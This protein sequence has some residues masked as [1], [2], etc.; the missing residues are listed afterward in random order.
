MR[1]P[2]IMSQ[3]TD[4]FPVAPGGTPSRAPSR[5]PSMIGLP[6]SPRISL[7][8]WAERTASANGL[9]LRDDTGGLNSPLTQASITAWPDGGPVGS[10]RNG[11]EPSSTAEGQRRPHSQASFDTA[12]RM[13]RRRQSTGFDR[14]DDGHSAY[15]PDGSH[16]MMTSRGRS[17]RLAPSRPQSVAE[18]DDTFGPVDS[19]SHDISPS[20]QNGVSPKTV[21]TEVLPSL[22]SLEIVDT[23]VTE[24][25]ANDGPGI[26]NGTLDHPADPSAGVTSRNMAATVEKGADV[27]TQ[28][29]KKGKSRKHGGLR[30]LLGEPIA[31][32]FDIARVDG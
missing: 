27:Q 22:A 23:S 8:R 26:A 18:A 4:Y 20:G 15:R 24:R 11:S 21:T 31:V 19:G 32:V 13:P 5:Q 3:M 16:L 14:S 17:R 28:A 7:R 25:A 10:R 30:S 1:S 29:A 12:P 9:G 6:P 2:S